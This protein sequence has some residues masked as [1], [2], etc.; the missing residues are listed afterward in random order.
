MLVYNVFIHERWLVFSILGG[1][2]VMGYS[3][4]AV[5]EACEAGDCSLVVDDTRL[6]LLV[7]G[8]WVKA[9]SGVWVWVAEVRAS[10]QGL[11]L[12]VVFEPRISSW[13]FGRGS[14]S[15]FQEGAGVLWVG[16]SLDLGIADVVGATRVLFWCG[17][18]RHLVKAGMDN[19]WLVPGPLAVLHIEKTTRRRRPRFCKALSFLDVWENRWQ[20]WEVAGE[21]L[22][23]EALRWR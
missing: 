1:G 21:T 7:G 15:F 14:S 10:A 12:A 23:V 8:D 6:V 17:V 3:S 9:G 11:V 19:L 22:F 16:V 18:V 4:R 20:L 13:V 5:T 2:E